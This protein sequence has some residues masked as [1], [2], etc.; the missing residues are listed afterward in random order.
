MATTHKRTNA[1]PPHVQLPSYNIPRMPF[2]S[3]IDEEILS[4][5][6]PDPARAENSPAGSVPSDRPTGAIPN[7]HS[8][9]GSRQRRPSKKSSSE[10]WDGKQGNNKASKLP[11]LNVVTNF[12]RPPIHAQRGGVEDAAG[13]KRQVYETNKGKVD[14][15][16]KDV[17]GLVDRQTSHSTTARDRGDRNR[18]DIPGRAGSRRSQRSIPGLEDR[19]RAEPSHYAAGLGLRALD[20]SLHKRQLSEKER[21]N[22]YYHLSPAGNRNAESSPD[23]SIAIGL[24]VPSDRLA[25]FAI[26]P[27]TATVERKS[28]DV[29]PYTQ[30]RDP[31]QTPN[32]IVTPAK[33]EALWFATSDEEH[34]PARRRPTSSVY[35]QATFYGRR[36]SMFADAPPVPTSFP[37]AYSKYDKE[38]KLKEST[39]FAKKSGRAQPEVRDSARSDSTVVSAYT[40]FDEEDS[41]QTGDRE[42]TYSGESQLRILDRSSMDTIATR[43]RSQGWWNTVLSPFLSRHNTIMA[44]NNPNEDVAISE[45]PSLLQAAAKAKHSRLSDEESSSIDSSPLTPATGGARSGHTSIWTEMSG[46][47]AER[48]SIGRAPDLTLNRSGSPKGVSNAQT[49]TVNVDPVPAGAVDDVNDPARGLAAEYLEA[50]RHDRDSPTPYFERQKHVSRSRDGA[51]ADAQK[52]NVDARAMHGLSLPVTEDAPRAGEQLVKDSFFQVPSN[53]FS[54]AFAQAT[55]T[56]P[57]A[58]SEFTEIE[59]DSTDPTPEVQEARVAPVVRARS[60]VLALQTTP[61]GSRDGPTAENFASPQTSV[62]GPPPYSP[63]RRAKPTKRYVAV[64]PPDHPGAISDQSRPHSPTALNQQRVMTSHD[65]SPA[66]EAPKETAS[67]PTQNTYI[68]N[69]YYERP[70]TYTRATSN[71]PVTLADLEPPPNVQYRAETKRETKEKLEQ[72]NSRKGESKIGKGCLYC[73]KR[74]FATKKRRRNCGITAGLLAMIIVVL[75]LA[76]TLTRKHKSMPVQSQWLNVTGYPPIPTGI[77]TIAQPDAVDEDSGCV[78]PATMWSC[79]LPKEQQASI[80]PN[81]PDQPNFRVQIFFSNGTASNTTAN[82][83]VNKRDTR[84][85]NAV[86]AGSFIRRRILAFRD[87]LLD[88]TPSPSPPSQNDQIFLGNTTDNNAAPFDG[89]ATPFYITFLP[90][91]TVPSVSQVLRRQAQSGTS[92]ADPFPDIASAIPAPSVNPNGT[93]ASATLLPLPSSQPLRLYNRGSSTEHYGFYN[94]FDRSIFLKNSTDATNAGVPSDQ[95]GGSTESEATV[96]CTWAQTRFL[97]QIW[98]NKGTSA[99]LLPSSN[100]TT[101]AAPTPT[102][103]SSSS[104]T[105]PNATTSTANDFSRPGSFPYPVSITL[106]RHGGD[107]ESK[108]IY[109]YG[110]DDR[111]A[112]VASEKSFHLEDRGFGG[113]LV[114]EADGP[115][116]NVTVTGD[117]GTA[118]WQGGIDGGSGGCSCR[119]QNWEGGS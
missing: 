96:R 93:A 101:P 94:Y 41:P 44:R 113:E 80:P 36:V 58:N 50:C 112:I 87:V 3:P 106:D 25:E 55:K 108:M 83:T 105:S 33:D 13:A 82:A 61:P 40:V 72:R 119:W 47:E 102:S 18:R 30:S 45:L 95:N 86:T 74:C 46:W 15:T 24:S 107:M 89:E 84:V 17:A 4:P 63:P 111:E 43:H 68:A 32:I 78:Q 79:A 99:S 20:R 51:V 109:C 77:A 64:M 22:P 16:I 39:S 98:T 34:R 21:K 5:I 48:G 116:G 118:G 23:G 19:L 38:G 67:H 110:M 69:H 1:T 117:G 42:R 56:R 11:A 71:A 97:V 49:G 81:E 65:I 35:S 100:S 9:D 66:A 91:T 26:S 88:Y 103:P 10:G 14:N 8:G 12:P 114:N 60:P 28:V 52:G 104:R 73:V 2:S 54:A 70:D 59:E 90:T 6:S 27:E 75:A 76:M 7:E 29:P 31:P 37:E 53:R 85:F 57:R 115:F 62:R 92:T